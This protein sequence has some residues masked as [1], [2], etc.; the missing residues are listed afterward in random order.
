MRHG[1]PQISTRLVHNTEAGCLSPASLLCT[2]LF[3]RKFGDP[4][5]V[6]KIPSEAVRRAMAK[7]ISAA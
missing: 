5:L 4:F 7:H 2:G 3:L 6:E 1:V